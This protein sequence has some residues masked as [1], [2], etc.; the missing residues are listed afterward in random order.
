MK[1]DKTADLKNSY[2]KGKKN[3]LMY[4][5]KCQLDLLWWSFYNIHKCIKSVCCIL[6]TNIYTHTHTHNIKLYVNYTT[7]KKENLIL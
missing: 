5:D 2:H 4:G 6:E 1:V 7:I 3:V